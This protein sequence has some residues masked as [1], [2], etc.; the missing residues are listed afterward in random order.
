MKGQVGRP[1]KKKKVSSYVIHIKLF[2]DDHLEIE[3]R[4][5]S[6]KRD[7]TD[8][9]RGLISAA[10][11]YERLAAVGK[12]EATQSVK[13]SQW[14]VVQKALAPVVEVLERL[15]AQTNILMESSNSTG[16]LAEYNLLNLLLLRTLVWDMQI[17]NMQK[18]QGIPPN[19]SEERLLKLATT[20]YP[21]VVR[22]RG[23]LNQQNVEEI[24]RD[25]AR[26]LTTPA[27]N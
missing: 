8:I 9:I 26:Q 14:E 27:K 24:I 12:D 21:T 25:F 18:E 10:L 6:T 19:V 13:L 7:R 3:R 23:K 22:E 17:R 15:T 2:Q 1:P 5:K 16:Q 20:M 4:M 11:R